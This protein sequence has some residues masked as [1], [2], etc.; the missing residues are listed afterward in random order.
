MTLR[1]P[2]ALALLTCLFSI[3]CADSA[4]ESSTDPAAHTRA[5]RATIP[6]IASLPLDSLLDL[7]IDLYYEWEFDSA[8]I[9]FEAVLDEA[10]SRGDRANYARTLTWMGLRAWRQGEFTEANSLG[11]AALAYKLEHGLD[12]QLFRS[13]NALGLV[14]WY[15]SRLAAAAHL[16]ERAVEA[17]RAAGDK[18]QEAAGL[19]NLALVQTDFGE[20]GAARDGFSAM[21]EVGSELADTLKMANALTNLGMLD[22]LLGNPSAAIPRL[23]EARGLYRNAEL[24]G[25]EEN[26]VAQLGTAYAALGDLGTAHAMFDTALAL[27]T[28]NEDP[29]ALAANTVALAEVYRDAGEYSRALELFAEAKALDQDLGMQLETGADLRSEA[30]IYAVLGELEIAA[31]RAAEALAI[32]RAIG[33]TFEEL[34]DLVTLAEVSQLQGRSREADRLLAE[35]RSRSEDLGARAARIEVW[36]AAARVR[37][38]RDDHL[39]AL[40]ALAELETDLERSGF[41]TRWEVEALRAEAYLA[42][43]ALDSAV[44]AAGRAVAALDRVRQ[45]MRSGVLRS[46]YAA[47]RMATYT[48]AVE[49]LLRNGD[50]RRAFEVADAARGRTLAER[51]T[52]AGGEPFAN[53]ELVGLLEGEELLRTIDQLVSS[54]DSLELA[55]G[56]GADARI[57]RESRDRQRRIADARDQYNAIVRRVRREQS[58]RGGLLHATTDLSSVQG[59]LRPGETLLEYLV[60]PDRL[61]IF[62]VTNADVQIL[63]NDISAEN[64][65]SRVRV[66]RELLGDPTAPAERSTAVLERL[67]NAVVAPAARSGILRGTTRLL[68]VPHEALTY[69]PFAALVDSITGRRL[70]EG[71]SIQHLPSAVTLVTLRGAEHDGRSVR[72]PSAPPSALAPFPGRL[73]ASLEEVSAVE[74]S[75]AGTRVDLG[76]MASEAR[77]R[78]AL[79]GG[80]VVH[81]ATHGVMNPRNPMSTRLE[82]ASPPGPIPADDGRL[83]VHELLSM[84]VEVPLVFLSGCETGLGPAWSTH[85]VRGEDFAT[86]AQAFLY[87]GAENVVASLWRIEDSG[88]AV[89]AGLFYEELREAPPAE[90]LARAQ[91]RM[92]EHPRFRSP[93][94]WAAYRLSG[95]GA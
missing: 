16:F 56:D 61:L 2:A 82:F 36:V 68:I 63:A 34:R 24:F 1:T 47:A 57:A 76:P 55:G 15:E 67:H 8:Q 53:P 11:E 7:G 19:G 17:A 39:A 26:P 62:A 25:H 12:A 66:A 45:T 4:A 74:R 50:K 72:P 28:E 87:A 48:T 94:H 59:V 38:A 54:L 90:A 89:F 65:T 37:A 71:Y 86:L 41:A 75:L 10:E 92:M 23:Q 60:T 20:F 30:E 18:S 35:A 58:S 46:S 3:G 95:R 22:I 84:H 85:Y 70:V 27:A 52:Q 43:G 44:A 81:I 93:Y 83:E 14:A 31:E 77:V 49:A 73:P 88:A 40:G 64:L 78:D 29:Q 33:A 79:A 32:H 69:L 6:G 9:V 13:Y 91:R 42:G 5:A 21:L 80:G 51:L